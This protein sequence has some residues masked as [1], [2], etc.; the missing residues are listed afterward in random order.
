MTT[1]LHFILKWSL[2][3]RV[4]RRLKI[5]RQISQMSTPFTVTLPKVTVDL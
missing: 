2:C 3:N 1:N 4:N 5:V